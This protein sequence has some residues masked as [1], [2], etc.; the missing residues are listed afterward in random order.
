MMTVSEVSRLS[1]VSIRTLQYYDR[2]GLLKP[3]QYSESGYRL[4][5]G[6]SLSLLRQIM[7]YRELEFPLGEIKRIMNQ[8]KEMRTE[9]FRQQAELL[10]LKRER[11]DRLIA[12]AEQTG[13][14]GTD[15]MDFS[16]FDTT[17]IEAYE[18][19]ARK[20]WGTTEAYHEY[21]QKSRGRSRDEEK[22]LGEQ[23]M[24]VIAGFGPL[25][26]QDPAAD[27]VQKRVEMLRGFITDHYY[28]CT[29]PVLKQ[30]GMMYTTDEFRR[31]IDA[32]GGAGTAEFAAEAIEEYC[33]ENKE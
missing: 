33:R 17:K 5:D 11:L 28:R 4:Y 32:A 29:V 10:K 7:L 2:I 9:V 26:D 6:E 24:T 15:E 30:L 18:E 31:N 14:G 19:Q 21:E 23:L 13:N 22:D 25:K 16:A 1:G 3:S 12:L 8:P 27:E 20:N